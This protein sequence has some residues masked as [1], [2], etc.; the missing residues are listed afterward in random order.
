MDK[1]SLEA[2]LERYKDLWRIELLGFLKVN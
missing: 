1:V 2:I